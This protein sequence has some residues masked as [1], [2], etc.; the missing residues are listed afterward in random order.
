[1]TARCVYLQWSIVGRHR[2]H[3]RCMSKPGQLEDPPSEVRRR[4]EAANASLARS[5]RA[6]T[7]VAFPPVDSAIGVTSLIE[8]AAFRRQGQAGNWWPL[9]PRTNGLLRRV[10]GEVLF[11]LYQVA[12]PTNSGWTLMN[13]SAKD[14]PPGMEPGCLTLTPTQATKKATETAAAG[15]H[16]FN[17]L[18][19]ASFHR[20]SA[21]QS[22][23]PKLLLE[24]ISEDFWGRQRHEGYG[25]I[26]LPQTGGR[27]EVEVPLWR[28]PSSE[29]QR[30]A[31]CGT[32]DPL[33]CR[34][35]I[36]YDSRG[37]QAGASAHEL[38]LKGDRFVQDRCCSGAIEVNIDTIVI[39]RSEAGDGR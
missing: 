18:Y 26:E 7:G 23:A 8:V 6:G 4:E 33:P 29:P 9:V 25:F 31:W 2:R 1:M 38:P 37:Q 21:G 12:V 32:F 11:V 30:D 14:L 20:Q 34:A 39:D 35:L 28:P 15:V 17:D 36:A 3:Q 10:M 27:L 16:V 19:Q 24:A 5:R 22:P 13:A